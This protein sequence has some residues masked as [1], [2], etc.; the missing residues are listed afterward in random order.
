MGFVLAAKF[1]QEIDDVYAHHVRTYNNN[2]LEFF[3]DCNNVRRLNIDM[4]N[5]CASNKIRCYRDTW[6]RDKCMEQFSIT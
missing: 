6:N 3:I 5:L 2:R 4:V 1:H